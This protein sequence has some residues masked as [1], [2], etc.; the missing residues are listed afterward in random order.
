MAEPKQIHTK[1][2]AIITS[3]EA[4]ELHASRSGRE[5]MDALRSVVAE[6][7]ATTLEGFAPEFVYN[8]YVLATALQAYAPTLNVLHR[9]YTV[10]EQAV[11]QGLLL[12]EFRA[13]ITDE[14]EAYI[15]WSEQARSRIA[16]IGKTIIP[17]DSVIYTFTLSET[18]MR[19]LLQAGQNGVR[20]SV[21][22]TESR[23]NND[24]RS[25]AKSLAEA[26]IPVEISIDAC[27]SELMRQADLMIIG[28]EAIL[29]DGSAICKTGTYASALV[30]REIGVPVYILADSMK[31]YANSL[32]GKGISLDALL[33]EE[34]IGVDLPTNTRVD[35]H[36]FD[37]TPPELITGLVTEMGILH[38]SQASQPM[39]AMPLSE[40]VVQR[41]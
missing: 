17:P 15:A 10:Y 12:T 7:S 13:A 4:K 32:L 40:F 23:P 16:A 1:V 29:A 37:R 14:A 27:M 25:T 28:A 6:T 2:Q 38:P 3:F 19:T 30:A 36:L 39:L 20:F 26:G 22:V 11:E 21:L 35:G 31:F 9:L 41:I 8:V 18:V 5:V 24:G 33:P 34:V